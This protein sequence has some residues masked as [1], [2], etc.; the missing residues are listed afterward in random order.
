VRLSKSFSLALPTIRCHCG[1][2][3]LLVPNVLSMNRAIEEHVKLH[4]K[5]IKDR[6]E[7]K[8]EAEKV[9]D[10]L[11]AEVFKKACEP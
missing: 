9:R 10:D 2:E 1:T 4:K 8:I 5:K 3:I 7:A 6:R 11:L